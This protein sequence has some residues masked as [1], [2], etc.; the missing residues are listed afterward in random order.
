MESLDAHPHTLPDI[1]ARDILEFWFGSPGSTEDGQSRA[2]W[3]KKDP[4]FDE[5]VRRRFGAVHQAAAADQL[6]DYWSATSEG[7]L[8]RVIVLDQFS[9][10]MY[11]DTPQAF[12]FDAKALAAAGRAVDAGLDSR[13]LPVQRM[14]LYLPFEHSEDLAQQRRSLALFDGLSAFPEMA[15]PIAYARR[16]YEVIARFG[17]FPHRNRILGRAS[18]PE[19]EEYLRQPGSG[20]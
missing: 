3:F 15:E 20:F 4:A 5:E 7:C 6:E 10:N 9:R 11:R 12:A 1:T 16:H 19:E 14:F 17:R 8:A 18:T 13:I 2:I